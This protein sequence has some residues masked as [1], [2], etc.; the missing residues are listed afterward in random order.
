[1]DLLELEHLLEHLLVRLLERVLEHLLV[2]VL[3]RLLEHLLVRLLVQGL[4][5]SLQ[6]MLQCCCTAPG[7]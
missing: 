7:G 6:N 3:V 4:L 1:M 2:R 5:A